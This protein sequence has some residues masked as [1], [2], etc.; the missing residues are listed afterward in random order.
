[1]IS[2]LNNITT[3]LG[4]QTVPPPYATAH[5]QLVAALTSDMQ[6]FSLRNA[7]IANS[8]NADWKQSNTAIGQA[9]TAIN[10]ALAEYPKGTVLANG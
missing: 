7:A 8:N 3:S 10:G 4:R 5:Q 1:M 6:G 9:S 2:T